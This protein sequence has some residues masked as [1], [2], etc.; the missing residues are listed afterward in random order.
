MATE[1]SGNPVSDQP[2]QLAVQVLWAEADPF[3]QDGAVDAESCRLMERRTRVFR[4]YIQG[5]SMREVAEDIKSSP[6]T[7]CRDVRHVL[8]GLRKVVRQ[9]MEQHVTRELGRL[10]VIEA[11]AWEAW[12]R[13]KGEQ[14]ETYTATRQ[15][16]A[17]VN[18][19]A[20]NA[21]EARQRRRVRDG[22][23]RFLQIAQGTWDRRCKLLGLLTPEDKTRVPAGAVKLVAGFS[24][25]ELV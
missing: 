8:N 1:Q 12:Q 14:T 2:G 19:P 6:A 18:Q 5:R 7:V 13:S 23:P 10:A 24:P 21:V 16:P 4:Q 11:E 22:D 15:R 3:E 9:D 20:G 17:G 25:E